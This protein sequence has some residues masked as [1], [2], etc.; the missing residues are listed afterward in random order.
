MESYLK[1]L[2][3]ALGR[4]FKT[5][6]HYGYVKLTNLDKLLVLTYVEEILTDRFQVDVSEEEYQEMSKALMCIMGSNCLIPYAQYVNRESDGLVHSYDS[7]V[8]MRN[9]EVG[10]EGDI[11]LSESGELREIENENLLIK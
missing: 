1:V 7:Q 5:L 10:T 9:T 3:E 2:A 6:I 11:R 4:Y 8:W